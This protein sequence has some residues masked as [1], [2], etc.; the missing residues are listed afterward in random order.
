M[1]HAARASPASAPIAIGPARS[2]P[3]GPKAK[4]STVR[5][6]FPDG[7]EYARGSPLSGR[8]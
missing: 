6:Q 7:A 8:R 2:A 1:A 5:G 3:A 4:A